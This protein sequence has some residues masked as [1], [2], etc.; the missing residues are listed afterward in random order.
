MRITVVDGV[1]ISNYIDNYIDNGSRTKQR[2]RNDGNREG[3]CASVVRSLSNGDREIQT[4][5]EHKSI[6]IQFI[7]PALMRSFVV[8]VNVRCV[9]VQSSRAQFSP[10][11]M[12]SPAS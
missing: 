7:L 8:V 11:W 6:M 3:R 12:C 10:Q 1:Y 4:D 5:Y 9:D 2:S